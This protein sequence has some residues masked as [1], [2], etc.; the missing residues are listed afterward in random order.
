[1][2]PIVLT[3][4]SWLRWVILLVALLALAKHIAGL[5]RGSAYDA[6]SARLLTA[7]SGLM[8]LQALIGLVT[9]IVGWRAFSAAGFPMNQVEH[10]STMLLAAIVAHLPARWKERPDTV[11]Y[12][13]GLIVV[14]AALVLIV[15]GV[16]VLVGNRWV[17]RGL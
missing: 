2:F 8:D 1:M 10:L 5:V 7:F 12:R 16:S 3:V 14:I 11:R 17:L 9:L 15:L 6:L 4:H 13:N